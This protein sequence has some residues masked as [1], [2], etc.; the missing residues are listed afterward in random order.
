MA[1]PGRAH[2]KGHLRLSLVSIPV[3]I[4]NTVETADNAKGQT[5]TAP[6]AEPAPKVINLM[7]ALKQS[8]QTTKAKEAKRP[9]RVRRKAG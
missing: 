5:I 7:Q 8:R 2:W 1:R 9:S 4:Y 3:E 6:Q